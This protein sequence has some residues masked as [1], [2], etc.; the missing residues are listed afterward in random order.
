VDGL[1]R[2]YRKQPQGNGQRAGEE[3][4][5]VHDSILCDRRRGQQPHVDCPA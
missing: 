2:R 5:Q 4:G 1:G 3:P